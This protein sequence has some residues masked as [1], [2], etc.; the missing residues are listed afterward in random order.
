MD[1]FNIQGFKTG[2]SILYR[3]R[4]EKQ[5]NEVVQMYGLM[6]DNSHSSWSK[7]GKEKVQSNEFPFLMLKG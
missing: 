7:R 3:K 2:S 6:V 4:V 5:R 1:L